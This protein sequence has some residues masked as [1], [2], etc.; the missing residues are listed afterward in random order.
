MQ[1]KKISKARTKWNIEKSGLEESRMHFLHWVELK[2]RVA[3]QSNKR[4]HDRPNRELIRYTNNL[5]YSG[6]E[7]K[8]YQSRNIHTKGEETSIDWK[9][10]G[11]TKE[12]KTE[13]GEF[14]SS[15]W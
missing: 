1:K 6:I 10:E 14:T 8:P 13:R 9:T 4:A 2:A 3:T 5:H 7:Q 12:M 11:K 15:P